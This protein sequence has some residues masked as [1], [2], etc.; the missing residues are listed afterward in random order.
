MEYRWLLFVHIG[1]VLVFMLAHGVHVT[2]TWKKR[3]ERDPA[4]NDALF[5]AMTDSRWL[6]LAA[7]AVVISGF[8]LVALL[9]LWTRAWIWVSFGLLAAIW[10]AMYRWGGAYYNLIEG[11]GAALVA[12]V[13]TPAEPSARAAFDRARLSRLVPAMT[14]VGIGG[15]ALILWLMVFRPS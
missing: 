1:A 13:G 15:V 4:Q 8:L 14:I 10:L 7:L 11:A 2:V 6:R 3:W 12:A 5:A 9:D